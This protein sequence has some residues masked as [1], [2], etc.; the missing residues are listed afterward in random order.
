MSSPYLGLLTL[1]YRNLKRIVSNRSP[2]VLVDALC[3]ALSTK[4]N[5]VKDKTNG[6]GWASRDEER[7]GQQP[8]AVEI[9][10]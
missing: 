5:E 4:I 10:F 9:R 1:P 2:S 8:R 6:P 3:A 7:R